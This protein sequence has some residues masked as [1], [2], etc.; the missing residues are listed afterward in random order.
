MARSL[1]RF[2][3]EVLAI[4]CGGAGVFFLISFYSYSPQDPSFSSSHWSGGVSN[5]CGVA[6]SFIADSLFQLFGV[7]ALSFP[8][9]FSFLSLMLILE[10]E[11]NHSL[12]RLFWMLLLVSFGAGLLNVY[13]PQVRFF[14]GRVSSAGIVGQ[15]LSFAL[16][17][18]VKP[19]GT[20]VVLWVAFLLLILLSFNRSLLEILAVPGT[21]IAAITG[22]LFQAVKGRAKIL[23]RWGRSGLAI[24]PKLFR[25]RTRDASPPQEFNVEKSVASL[26]IDGDPRAKVRFPKTIP[27]NITRGAA[28]V[29][30]AATWLSAPHAGRIE[31]WA[32][33]KLS[34]LEDPP[35]SRVRVDEREIRKKGELL[36]EKLAL[37]NVTGEI[38]AARP[39]PVV[40]LFEF[41][42]DADVK[43]SKITELADDLALALSS[44]SLRILAPIPGRDVVGVETSNHQRELVYLKDMISDAEFWQEDLRLPVALGKDASGEA[45]IV[46]LRRMPHLM[47]AGTTGSGKSVFTVS[48]ITGLLFRHSPKTLRLILIDPKQVDLAAFEEIP[49]LLTPVVTDV[50]HAV[51]TLKWAVREMEKRY[52]SM[53]KF[54][55]R[56]LEEYNRN[57]GELSPEQVAEHEKINRESQGGSAAAPA[58]G[59][60]DETYYFQ[61]LPYLVIVVEEFADLMVADKGQVEN[62]VVRLAQKARACGIHLMLCMQ[63]PRKEVVTGLIRTNFS[64][65]V[66]FKVSDAMESR[67]I[68][69]GVGAERLLAQGDMLFKGLGNSNLLRYHG[70]FLK[71]SDIQSVTRFWASQGEPSFDSQLSRILEDGG[72]IAEATG[73]GGEGDPESDNK[74]DEILAWASTQKEVSASLIQ[75]R[76]Q[77]GYP[78][79]AR[80][81][82]TFE[83]Q[84]VVGPASGSKPRKVLVNNLNQLGV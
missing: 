26:V 44:E 83:R 60:K 70:P 36:K 33:P 24:W 65:R 64:S 22:Y 56:G 7:G 58:T 5:A 61:A 48:T 77:L 30:K 84:G 12:R 66:A 18:L 10:A 67:I 57:V 73:G 19:A 45:R 17:K 51:L 53:S 27:A 34:E 42:P 47:V 54:G 32:L 68:L 76:F 43:L 38:V 14:H 41:K 37:F 55:A 80:L 28:E 20:Q 23:L 69:D 16:L 35:A 11:V 72:E 79:A 15:G 49:H 21:G 31:N 29:P 78:R 39:G 3:N 71:D 75:R 52:K 59:G 1:N 4:V 82:E 81:I 9:A 13:F 74:Y 62:S 46:D 25:S 63:S 2:K 6:G 40:T 8:I 50:K